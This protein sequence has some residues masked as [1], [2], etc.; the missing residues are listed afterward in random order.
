MLGEIEDAL[1][2]RPDWLRIPL[3]A[4]FRTLSEPASET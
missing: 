3:N 4:L 1:L 2:H